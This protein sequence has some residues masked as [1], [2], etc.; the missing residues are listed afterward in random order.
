MPIRVSRLDLPSVEEVKGVLDDLKKRDG[1]YCCSERWTDDALAELPV[2]I[3][4]IGAHDDDGAV[5]LLLLVPGFL[6]PWGVLTDL[7]GANPIVPFDEDAARIHAALLGE[8]S[9]WIAQEELSGLE[10]LLPM[11]PAN[12]QPDRRQDAFY[13]GLGFKRFYYT[14]TRELDSMDDCPERGAE[15]EVVPAPAIRV[16]E[17]YDNYVAC[18]A[19]GEIEL[20]AKQSPTARR[21][22]FDSLAEDTL[23][24]PG[25]VALLQGD[26]L[27]GFVLAAAMSETAAHLAWIGILPDQRGQGLGRLLLCHMME[28][29]KER[30]IERMSLYTD[31]SAGA[32][33]LYHRLGFTTAGALTY[34][35]RRNE[36]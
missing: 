14:M 30:Q 8:A 17:L 25:S 2:N 31:T 10:I 6:E 12:M 27:L 9:G 32:Q 28:T 5:A 4:A 21:E 24:H 18:T 26:Q 29:C 34:R 20:V 35:W 36:G 16:D 13:E 33:T 3:R 23:G 19:S 22:Y 7:L 11:G 1:R 15:F